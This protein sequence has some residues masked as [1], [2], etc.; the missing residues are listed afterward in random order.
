LANPTFKD[1]DTRTLTAVSTLILGPSF[2]HDLRVN[3][4]PN[5]GGFGER[6]DTF[7]GAVPFDEALIV[8]PQYVRPG[9]GDNSA[10]FL[11]FPGLTSTG[12]PLTSVNFSASSQN[13]FNLVDVVSWN[14]G[15][16]QVKGGLDYRSLRPDLRPREYL[17]YPRFLA[18]SQVLAGVAATGAVTST[19]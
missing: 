16:H 19:G 2:T 6:L 8:P 18:A 5:G 9:A 11:Q 13:Q 10:G 15:R 1:L 4:T 14:G 3:F 12:F 7:G 17:L